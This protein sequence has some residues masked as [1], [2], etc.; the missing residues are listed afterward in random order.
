MV[1]RTPWAMAHGSNHITAAPR[2][3]PHPCSKR[4]IFQH[5]FELTRP[6]P[7]EKPRK[8]RKPQPKKPKVREPRVPTKTP[9]EQRE[10]RR[11]YDQARNQQSERKKA[12][13]LQAQKDRR[14]R[15]AAGQ[16]KTCPNPAIPG[17]TRCEACR[18]KHRASS[19]QYG[20]KRREEAR[21]TASTAP[22][23][24]K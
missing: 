7:K 8:I 21:K 18:D 9:E 11:V 12:A 20:T 22:T 17:Q 1:V 16:C 10:A 23:G 15:K 14:E 24:D 3:R 2:V 13:R 5:T 19:Q 6:E 4:I